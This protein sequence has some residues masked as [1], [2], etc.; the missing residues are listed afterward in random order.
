MITLLIVY[1]E[2]HNLQTVRVLTSIS[3]PVLKSKTDK[4]FQEKKETV[5]VALDFGTQEISAVLDLCED[6]KKKNWTPF[7]YK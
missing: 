3:F 1:T 4:I 2:L 5:S 6:L 7:S